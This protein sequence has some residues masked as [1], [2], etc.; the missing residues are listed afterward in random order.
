MKLSLSLFFFLAS[1]LQL[2]CSFLLFFSLFFVLS[3]IVP[4]KIVV[5]LMRTLFTA[6][7][8]DTY[9]R[10]ALKYEKRPPP[11]VNWSCIGIIGAII[12]SC[13]PRSNVIESDPIERLPGISHSMALKLVRFELKSVKHLAELKDSN[14]RLFALK[15]EF[16]TQQRL[17]DFRQTA[18]EA[19]SSR[20]RDNVDRRGMPKLKRKMDVE[21]EMTGV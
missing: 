21:I 16:I 8:I 3:S 9:K 19:L 4:Q 18:I 10:E 20:N 12:P 14:L 13:N 15:S 2:C 6:I 5:F 1:D 17:M 11:T 7:V